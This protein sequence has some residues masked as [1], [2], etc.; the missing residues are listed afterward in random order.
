MSKI[1]IAYNLRETDPM[2]VAPPRGFTLIKQKEP[3]KVGDMLLTE[4]RPG[5][6]RGPVAE[7]GGMVGKTANDLIDKYGVMVKAARKK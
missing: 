5:E 6:W 2:N 4:F 1:G 3:L 7:K